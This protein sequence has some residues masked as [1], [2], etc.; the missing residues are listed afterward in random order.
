MHLFTRPSPGSL[1]RWEKLKVARLKSQAIL[2]G[3]VLIFLTQVTANMVKRVGEI[4]D[5]VR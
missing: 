1:S 3:T 2:L 5:S 4:E